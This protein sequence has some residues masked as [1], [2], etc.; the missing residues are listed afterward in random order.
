MQ[1]RKSINS[2]TAYAYSYSHP[3]VARTGQL[4]SSPNELEIPSPCFAMGKDKT[5]AIAKIGA[6][7]E[8]IQAKFKGTTGGFQ[9][10][11]R[12]VEVMMDK[13]A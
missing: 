5:T 2:L 6:K 10:C 7:D 12:L 13:D 8:E 9:A 3:D 4:S 11:K 1:A